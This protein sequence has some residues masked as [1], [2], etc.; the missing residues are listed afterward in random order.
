MG[1]KAKRKGVHCMRRLLAQLREQYPEELVADKQVKRTHENVLWLLLHQEGRF[2]TCY[3]L[4]TAMH[5]LGWGLSHQVVSV[6]VIATLQ[7]QARASLR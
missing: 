3:A 6:S 1:S 2:S 5:A 4:A 7:G